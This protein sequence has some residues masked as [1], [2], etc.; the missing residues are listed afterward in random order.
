MSAPQTPGPE[1]ADL[2]IELGLGDA[3][4]A[5]VDEATARLRNELLQL[6]VDRVQRASGGE[7]PP[8]TRAVELVALGGLVVTLARN[9]DKIAA[10]IHTLEGWLARDRGRTIKLELDGDNIEVSGVSSAERERLISAFI[11]RHASG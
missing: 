6:D 2:Q 9:S 5:E 7:A 4:P 1:Q 10:V 8:G 3:D 11:E